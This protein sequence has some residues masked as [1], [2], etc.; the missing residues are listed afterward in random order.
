MRLMIG[1]VRRSRPGGRRSDKRLQPER[2]GIEAE[3]G[4]AI[5]AGLVNPYRM[6]ILCHGLSLRGSALAP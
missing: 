6:M 1:G 3:G 2:L 4:N 5:S